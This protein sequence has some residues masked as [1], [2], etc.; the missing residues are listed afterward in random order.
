MSLQDWYL[1]LINSRYKEL[2]IVSLVIFL[3]AFGSVMYNYIVNG[4]FFELSTEITGGYLIILPSKASLQD[5]NALLS[6]INVSDYSIYEVGGNFYIEAR[7]INSDLLIQELNAI[8]ISER[9]ISIQRF[10]S[11]VGG[12]IFNQLSL[13]LIISTLIISFLIWVRFRERRSVIGI[14]SVILWDMFIT[15]ALI[16]LVKLRVGPV[17]L[18]TLIGILG[19]AIDN[20]IVLSTNV[21]Q[22]KD[23][24]F[25]DRIK[26]SLKVGLLM[27]L[28]VVLV[29]IPLYLLID[30]P[31][32]KEFSLIWL[33]IVLADSYA[34]L[35][36]NV[37]L[38][39]YFEEI[40][41][42]Q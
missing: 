23:L 1:R 26:M 19:F 40:S 22:E 25:D 13:L 35:F 37:P 16:N 17:G 21:Y 32:I 12:I 34:Y 4:K 18:V 30:L 24:S 41:K 11:Y 39:R 8:G 2:I 28:F 15:L 31:I 5:L 27:E 9:E 20:N 14:I 36:F 10:S 38:Y 29:V 3:I 33:F 42:H 6:K 7:D